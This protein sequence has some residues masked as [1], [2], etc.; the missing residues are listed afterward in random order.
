MEFIELTD[1]QRPTEQATVVIQIVSGV[2]PLRQS[3]RRSLLPVRFG[4]GSLLRLRLR[5]LG[6]ASGDAL[7]RNNTCTDHC[8]RLARASYRAGYGRLF[9]FNCWRL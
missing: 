4:R 2:P 5:L 9:H 1:T 6:L 7:C 8:P 3:D